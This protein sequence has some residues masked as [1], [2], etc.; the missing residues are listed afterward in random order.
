MALARVAPEEVVH[1]RIA[2]IKGLAIMRF[3]DG[4]LS[5]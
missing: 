3:R 2:A 4:F 1:L 5:P